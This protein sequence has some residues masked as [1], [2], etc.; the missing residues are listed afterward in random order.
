[1]DSLKI[2]VGLILGFI[3]GILIYAWGQ[4]INLQTV[5]G[6]SMLAAVYD[7]LVFL[8]WPILTITILTRVIF[9][10]FQQGAEEK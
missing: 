8:F 2:A 7:L 4:G 5:I 3:I 6:S 1:M 10:M 9:S